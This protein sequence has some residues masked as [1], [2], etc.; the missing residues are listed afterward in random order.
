M[1]IDQQML[2][3]SVAKN[4]EKAKDDVEVAVGYLEDGERIQKRT[5]KWKC[6]CLLCLLV[7]IAVIIMIVFLRGD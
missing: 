2:I 3:D 4:V 5:R 7:V 1:V 6:W